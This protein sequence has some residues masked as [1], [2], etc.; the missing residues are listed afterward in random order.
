MAHA[1][2]ITIR[3]LRDLRLLTSGPGR[4]TEAFGIT[5][6][7]DNGCDLT[8][9]ESS[10]WIGDD[11]YRPKQIVLSPRIGITKAADWKLRYVLAGSP[12]V[13]RPKLVVATP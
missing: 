1:R 11:A 6:V 4:L 13:S 12:F 9:L 10:L 2:G 8:S 7:R 5:R 3:T